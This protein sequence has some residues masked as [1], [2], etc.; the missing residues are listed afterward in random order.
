MTI[1]FITSYFHIQQIEISDLRFGLY[2]VRVTSEDNL[3]SRT[4]KIEKM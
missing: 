3:I 4:F 2:F 1:N